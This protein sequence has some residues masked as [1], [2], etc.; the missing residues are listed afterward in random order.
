LR[1]ISKIRHIFL[2]A[3]LSHRV[4]WTWLCLKLD[5]SFRVK[6]GDG[7]YML[8]A[9]TSSIKCFKCGGARHK[10]DACPH[11]PI[12]QITNYPQRALQS[13]HIRHP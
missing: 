7:H 2:C 10:R 11:S 4:H 12:S 8:Y 1:N 6:H 9:T 13:V 5:V 3:F